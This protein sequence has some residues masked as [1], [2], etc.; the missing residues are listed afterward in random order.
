MKRSLLIT[1]ISLALIS[2]IFAASTNSPANPANQQQP[3]VDADADNNA[4]NPNKGDSGN[5]MKLLASSTVTKEDADNKMQNADKAK[6]QNDEEMQNSQAKMLLA[7]GTANQHQHQGQAD[8]NQQC[9]SDKKMKK[10]DQTD[11]ASA[12]AA[13]LSV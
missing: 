11:K 3:Q 6:Q 1:G 10:D 7:G 12:P 5:A 2:Q 13:E 4:N 9:P 8:C